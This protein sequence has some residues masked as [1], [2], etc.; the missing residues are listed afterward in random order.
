MQDLAERLDLMISQQRI[1]ARVAALARHVD[2]DYGGGNLTL[3]V[4]LK[5]AA[6]FAADLMR[7][8]AIPFTV[9]YI[10]ASSYGAATRSSGR[11]GLRGIDALELAGRDVLIIED[12]LDSGLTA[13]AVLESV[14][15]RRPA[16]LALLPL[17]RK[18]AAPRQLLPVPQVGFDIADEFVVGYGMDFAE[19]YRNLPAIYRLTR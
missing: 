12:I 19:R 5:G 2:E 8:I 15:Q 3:V 1:R 14:R 6:I 17:L 13:G 9:E 7:R 4:V 10:T 16:S 18:P 11:V